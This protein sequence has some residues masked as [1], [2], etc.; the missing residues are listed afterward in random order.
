MSKRLVISILLALAAGI[1]APIL[2]AQGGPA[3]TVPDFKDQGKWN[4]IPPTRASYRGKKPSTAP[5]PKRDL[6]G[7]WDSG[8]VLGTSGALEHPALY[9]G[10]K[11]QEGGHPDETG[12]EKPLPF[13]PA[14]L[15]ALKKNKPSGPSV[16]QVDAALTNDPAGKCDPLGFPYMYLWEFRTID[17]VQSSRQVVILSPFYGNYRI[18]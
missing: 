12:V 5:I 8:Q 7:I 15:E 14:G 6:S 10:G 2:H 18:I 11:G 3:E 4:N 16:R 17:V 13:T 9:P 1:F